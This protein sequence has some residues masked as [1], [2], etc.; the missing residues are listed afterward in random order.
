MA[1]AGLAVLA[2]AAPA[3]ANFGMTEKWGQFG[4][5]P[6]LYVPSGVA[7]DSSGNAYVV[8]QELD[9]VVKFNAAGTAVS[10]FGQGVLNDAQ[11]VAVN[12]TSGVVYVADRY[13]NQ[14]ERFT[15]A[16]GSLGAWSA[17][18][19]SDVDV[20][21]AGNVYI[22]EF[23]NA[24]IVKR[25]PDGSTLANFGTLGSGDGQLWNPAGVAVDATGSVYVADQNNN[26]VQQLAADGT[27][28]RK[29]TV[30]SPQAIA[31]DGSSVYVGHGAIIDRY[32]LTGIPTATWSSTASGSFATIKHLAV[33]G[34][35]LL[36][37]ETGK[38]RVTGLAS[39][40]ALAS[41]WTFDG[42]GSGEGA[43]RTVWG[44]ARAANG[45]IY[46]VDQ[47]NR[48]VQRFSATGAF[49][50]AFGSFGVGDGQFKI[51][52]AIAVHPTS[53]DVYVSDTD[54][55]VNRVQRFS[56]TGAFISVIATGGSGPGQVN[57][58]YDMEFA[59]DGTLYLGET[60]NPRIQHL[61]ATGAF[62]EA[63]P[64]TG[65]VRGFARASNGDFYVVHQSS[66]VERYSSTGQLLGTYGG[67][68]APFNFGYVVAAAIGSDGDVYVVD[69][70]TDKVTRMSPT[71]T[72]VEAFGSSG[73]GDGA[74]SD[75][76]SLIAAPNGYLYV[77]DR[78]LERIQ[79]FGQSPANQGAPTPSAAITKGALTVTWQAVTDP[80][81]DA[82]TYELQRQ[83]S[84]NQD[85]VVAS[86]LTG[87][88]Y[89]WT[90]DNPHPEGRYR[91]YL[92]ATDGKLGVRTVASAETIVDRTPPVAVA[93][94]Y[95]TFAA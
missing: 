25:A 5:P 54:P 81:G 17:S 34:G 43:F 94:R 76:Q 69:W 14:V 23:N 72:F 50:G 29:W 4:I 59:P 28:V 79:R 52:R 67:T 26:R 46:A 60:G 32:S 6:S 74:F 41:T 37:T 63:I 90:V 15:T 2:I 11:G 8:D 12:S 39:N 89:S 71:G 87:T 55:A 84:L 3:Q 64:V 56:S 82:V 53:G 65:G 80:N 61:S 45:D 93:N 19:P 33:S 30:T 92:F 70:S 38:P 20:D 47:G 83:N 86:G 22:S 10:A 16:G 1:V 36:M 13:Q 77:S 21:S 75:P 95:G 91:Y 88:S 85:A 58:V 78:G 18:Q 31:V 66:V 35:T 62:I 48:R 44:I 7:V 42:L 24:R 40:G 9:Q 57:G 73:S 49:L 51:P 68:A 27:F